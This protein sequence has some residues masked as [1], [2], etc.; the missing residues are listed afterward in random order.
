MLRMLSEPTLVTL[1]GRPATFIAG[2]EF[3]VP[4]TVGVNGVGAVT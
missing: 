2:G 4:T 1:S 3:A